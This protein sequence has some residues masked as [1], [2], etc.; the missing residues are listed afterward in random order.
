MDF[1]IELT[2]EQTLEFVPDLFY[3][4]VQNLV[5]NA[6]KYRSPKRRGEINISAEPVEH[7]WQLKVADNGLGMDME[8][9]EKLL[10]KMFQ[11]FHDHVEGKGIGLHLVKNIVYTNGGK[12]EVESELDKGTTFNI[13]LPREQAKSN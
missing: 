9:N 11:R 3:S 6:I 13:F 12:I 5:T 10:F 7:Y 2:D 1:N 8:Q 4:V